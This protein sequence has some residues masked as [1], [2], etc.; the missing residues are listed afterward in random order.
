MYM[1]TLARKRLNANIIYCLTLA[2]GLSNIFLYLEIWPDVPQCVHF[3]IVFQ[4]AINQ[5]AMK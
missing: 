4:L 3:L 5:E 2:N 1:I